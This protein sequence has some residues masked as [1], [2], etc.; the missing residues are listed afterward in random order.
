MCTKIN[1]AILRELYTCVHQVQ[2]GA[3]TTNHETNY[4]NR[5][6]EKSAKK[7]HAKKVVQVLTSLELCF[8]G[9]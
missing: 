8:L 2:N 3:K 1:G 4:K 6:I 5:I 9:A 7:H